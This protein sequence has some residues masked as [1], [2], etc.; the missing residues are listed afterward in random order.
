MHSTVSRSGES[1]TLIGKVL[2]IVFS[3]RSG[4]WEPGSTSRSRPSIS[5]LPWVESRIHRRFLASSAIRMLS[6]RVALLTTKMMFG[7][8]IAFSLTITPDCWPV[9][10][11]ISAAIVAAS[12]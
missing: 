6:Q 1:A 8:L 3:A 5:S 10:S 9:R 12:G 2:L 7:I 11:M 4:P